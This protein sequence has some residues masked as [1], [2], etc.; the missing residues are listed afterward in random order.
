MSSK[1][2][3]ITVINRCQKLLYN[4]I[5]NKIKI[6]CQGMSAEQINNFAWKLLGQEDLMAEKR[7]LKKRLED[8]NTELDKFGRQLYFQYDGF[9]HGDKDCNSNS[10]LARAQIK[11]QDMLYPQVKKLQKL[12]DSIEERT[13][14]CIAPE[15]LQA[16]LKEV[17]AEI[18]NC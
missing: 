10:K 17:K 11:A 13:L 4:M 7:E 1:M 15:D 14:L 2:V 8:I 12:K 9:S 16:L 3:G 6:A 18:E 5:D